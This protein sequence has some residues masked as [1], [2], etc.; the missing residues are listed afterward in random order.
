M[1]IIAHQ[2]NS[3]NIAEIVSS[4]ILI[5]NLADSLDILGNIYYQGYDGMILQ[6]DNFDPEFFNLSNGLAGE[7]LQKFST[8]KLRLVIV[9]DFST[10]QGKS[11][12]SFI[13]ESNERKHINFVA[14]IQEALQLFEN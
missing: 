5:N 10:L 3:L 14:T 8:Y 13:T 4:Q 2:L 12:R 11:I 1:E 6:K 7:I 9:G